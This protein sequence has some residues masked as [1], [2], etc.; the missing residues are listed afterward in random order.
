MALFGRRV[1]GEAHC[2]S[3]FLASRK[4]ALTPALFPQ[5]R[6]EREEK[7]PTRPQFQALQTGR[8]VKADLALQAERL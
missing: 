8:D 7:L 3:L 6:A 5:M 1:K 2:L 4:E